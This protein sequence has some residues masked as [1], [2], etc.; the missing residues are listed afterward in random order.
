MLV[1]IGTAL[2]M[3]PIKIPVP[4]YS[5]KESRVKLAR[6]PIFAMFPVRSKQHLKLI[7]VL[8]FDFH[9]IRMA[10]ISIVD[11]FQRSPSW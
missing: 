2:Y 8:V 1:L 6:K 9:R 10:S 5:K 3:E 7:Y 4:V 11:S